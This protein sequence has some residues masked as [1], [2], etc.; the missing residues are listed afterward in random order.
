MLMLV[1]VFASLCLR[2]PVEGGGAHPPARA[3]LQRE[4]P[5]AAQ[6]RRR[7][8]GAKQDR[9]PGLLWQGWPVRNGNGTYARC[10]VRG[11]A[12]INHLNSARLALCLEARMPQEGALNGKMM[13]LTT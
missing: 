2:H 1:L 9:Q 4:P 12:K 13:S 7:M 10:S 8:P 11:G 6:Q 3:R 5:P